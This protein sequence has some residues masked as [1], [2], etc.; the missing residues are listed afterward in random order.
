MRNLLL[1][2]LLI[3][4]VNVYAEPKLN[5]FQGEDSSLQVSYNITGKD[6]NIFFEKLTDILKSGK[7]VNVIHTIA[8]KEKGMFK[9]KLVV[10][11]YVFPITYDVLQNLY[12][13]DKEG[14]QASNNTKEVMANILSLKRLKIIEKNKLIKGKTYRIL[15]DI[16][17]E[18][19][20][21]KKEEGFSKFIAKIIPKM[22]SSQAKLSYEVPYIAR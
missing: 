19:I 12:V 15:I 8:L 7:K 22:S 20:N 11:K 4:S 6:A 3:F 14:V 21:K 5:T 18:E 16:Y 1:L 17:F 13:Y 10:N 2:F 9:N